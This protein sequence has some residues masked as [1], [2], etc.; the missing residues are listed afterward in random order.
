M[1]ANEIISNSQISQLSINDDDKSLDGTKTFADI[2]AV[3]VRAIDTIN[4]ALP[5]MKEAGVDM[6]KAAFDAELLLRSIVRKGWGGNEVEFYVTRN[7]GQAITA[8]TNR[9]IDDVAEQVSRLVA[10]FET[11]SARHDGQQQTQQRGRREL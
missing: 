1:D 7:D 4:E 8:V 9:H 3:V 11:R 5:K 2:K 6:K 10:N